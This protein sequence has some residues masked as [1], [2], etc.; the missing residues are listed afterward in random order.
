MMMSPIWM[1]LFLFLSVPLCSGQTELKVS[2]S[3][4]T[5]S[6]LRELASFYTASEA[7]EVHLSIVEKPSSAVVAGMSA[8]FCKDQV[9]TVC[10]SPTDVAGAG[11]D[12]GVI[13]NVNSESTTSS[14]IL[15]PA[16]VVALVAVY[17]IPSLDGKAIVVLLV[18]SFPSW[19]IVLCSGTCPRLQHDCRD[20]QRRHNSLA[21]WTH[22]GSH[23]IECISPK[24]LHPRKLT[25]INAFVLTLTVS[26]LVPFSECLTAMVRTLALHS[27]LLWV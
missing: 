5:A 6:S 15:V 26:Y 22:S 1:F 7:P 3:S 11:A 10:I 23:R 18:F 25:T 19:S 27:F 24:W 9:L 20:I 12:F 13:A 16:M 2:S 14:R 4:L 21:R 8:T 17:N